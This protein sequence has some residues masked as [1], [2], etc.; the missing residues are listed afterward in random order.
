ML[1]EWIYIVPIMGRVY[2]NIAKTNID[3]TITSTT[4]TVTL[5]NCVRLRH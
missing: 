1:Q 3:A 5:A 2:K 4:K